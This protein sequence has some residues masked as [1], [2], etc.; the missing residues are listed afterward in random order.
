MA[1]G[2][3]NLPIEDGNSQL[4]NV[5]TWSSTGAIG[6]NLSPMQAILGADGLTIASAANGFPVTMENAS[7]AITAAAL[8]LPSGAATSA[9]QTTGN[10]SLASLVT[11]VGG[12]QATIVSG[13]QTQAGTATAL[14]TG[15]LLNGVRVKAKIGNSAPIYV[16]PSGVS[17]S[18]GYELNPSDDV[19][20]QVNN[21]NAAFIV[22]TSGDGVSF[23]GN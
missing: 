14:G 11:A 13:Q 18:T 16:G 19:L 15:A 10:T 17:T 7:V 20:V 21:L 23:V 2:P 9:L 1:A 4:R 6:G 22:G 12:V 3:I 8:P 5:L